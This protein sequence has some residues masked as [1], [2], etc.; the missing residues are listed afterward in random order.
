MA[1]IGT[2]VTILSLIANFIGFQ[3]ITPPLP[4][5]AALTQPNAQNPFI[6]SSTAYGLGQSAVVNQSALAPQTAP[7]GPTGYIHVGNPF[8]SG[9]FTAQVVQALPPGQQH[10]SALCAGNTLLHAFDLNAYDLVNGSSALLT[11]NFASGAVSGF[12][13]NRYVVLGTDAA[14]FNGGRGVCISGNFLL[15]VNQP[16]GWVSVPYAKAACSA[17]QPLTYLG[18]IAPGNIDIWEDPNPASGAGSLK[19]AFITTQGDAV[20]AEAGADRTFG[21]ADDVIEYFMSNLPLPYPASSIAVSKHYV[22]LLNWNATMQPA[23]SYRYA[24]NDGIFGTADDGPTTSVTSGLPS[25]P[26]IRA[27]LRIDKSAADVSFGSRITWVERDIQS[28]PGNQIPS[29]H[30]FANL[31]PS[32]QIVPFFVPQLGTVQG[33][34]PALANHGIAGGTIIYSI[35]DNPPYLPTLFKR[36]PGIDGLWGTNDDVVQA[37]LT[38][39]SNDMSID[40]QVLDQTV[41]ALVRDADPNGAPPALPNQLFII[42]LGTGTA[43]PVAANPQF[44][45]NPLNIGLA[46]AGAAL[47]WYEG[48]GE[49]PV[50]PTFPS[51]LESRSGQLYTFSRATGIG[52]QLTDSPVIPN[53]NQAQRGSWGKTII[54]NII[55]SPGYTNYAAVSQVCA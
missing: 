49:L 44:L 21:T 20:V 3:W 1:G 11:G 37:L 48:E 35:A 51:P 43:S 14:Q 28:M 7:I 52:S 10:L 41:L 46:A 16:S 30:V 36:Q 39:P 45:S 4:A 32:L 9:Q 27:D 17:P 33:N 31:A 2:A 34:N 25:V 53:T 22:V 55:G 40:A 15:T 8:S 19:I 26:G 42:D 23:F 6:F 54:Y 50:N 5:T 13:P 18:P 47:T 38:A 24:G 12:V 29:R